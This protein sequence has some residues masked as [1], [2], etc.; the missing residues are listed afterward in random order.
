MGGRGVKLH[1]ILLIIVSGLSIGI[2]LG[3]T[4]DEWLSSNGRLVAPILAA[5]V[6]LLIAF[7]AYPWQKAK[8]RQLELGREAREVAQSFLD[9]LN[10]GFTQIALQG[11]MTPE[12]NQAL[13]ASM[14]RLTFYFDEEEIDLCGELTQKKMELGRS[15]LPEF[16]LEET[17][18]DQETVDD[19]TKRF[20]TMVQ[21]KF[22]SA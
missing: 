2:T 12:A 21:E 3:V 1:P 14:Q 18:I 5:F 10:V 16:D 9:S 15:F 22:H 11:Q 19:V 20:V 4:I 7:V 17:L 8:D 6:A 13:N